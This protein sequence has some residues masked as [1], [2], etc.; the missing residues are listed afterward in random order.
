MRS[1]EGGDWGGQGENG[2]GNIGSEVLAA[3]SWEHCTYLIPCVLFCLVCQINAMILFFCKGARKALDIKV[4]RAVVLNLRLWASY[5]A[6][7]KL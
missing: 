6:G 3:T 5:G 7:S 2:Q 4:C 1:F